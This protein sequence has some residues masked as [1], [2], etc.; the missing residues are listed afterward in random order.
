MTTEEFEFLMSCDYGLAVDVDGELEEVVLFAE[1]PNEHD[2]LETV[3][4]SQEE[5]GMDVNV[6]VRAATRTEVEVIKKGIK[7]GYKR[8]SCADN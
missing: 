2:V 7:N 4:E 3:I 6:F 5:Y 1:L 8:G